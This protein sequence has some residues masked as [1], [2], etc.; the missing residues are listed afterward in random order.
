MIITKR[1]DDQPTRCLFQTKDKNDEW[2]T[3]LSIG[4]YPLEE[5]KQILVFLCTFNGEINDNK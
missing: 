4:E 5:L 1:P 2:K 3:Y